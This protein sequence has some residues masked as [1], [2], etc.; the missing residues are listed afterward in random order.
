[1]GLLISCKFSF[2]M[3]KCCGRGPVAQ[4]A[5]Q[6]PLKQSVEGSSPSWLTIV[7]FLLTEISS[8]GFILNSH[9]L[10]YLGFFFSL[11]GVAIAITDGLEDAT[12]RDLLPEH[13]RCTGYGTLAAVNGVGD[14]VSSTAVGFL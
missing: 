3:L 9:S 10:L 6:L 7:G 2:E 13:L 1:M 8:L 11:A 12:A 14:F 4:L 5:E